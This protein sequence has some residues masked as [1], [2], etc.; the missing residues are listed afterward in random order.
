MTISWLMIA[1]LLHEAEFFEYKLQVIFSRKEDDAKTL[2]ERAK[3]MYNH[4][5]LWLKNLCLLDRK[6]KDMPY[7]NIFFKGGSKILGFAQGKDQV[8]S[9]VPTTVLLDEAAFQD[10]LE[11]TYGACV[12]CCSR[13]ITVSSA[14]PG[15]F[16]RLCEKL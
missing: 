4:Q 10:K 5:P 8:R 15:Y 1:L 12:P 13:I 2:V 16:Q 7:G 3:F 6:M 9:Y 14:N 11:E